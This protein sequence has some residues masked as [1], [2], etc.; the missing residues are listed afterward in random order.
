MFT[1]FGY[2]N[3]MDKGEL[4]DYFERNYLN[5]QLAHG[6]LSI[7]KL[8]EKLHLSKGY[9][10]QLM[11]G[12][13]TSVTY[14][15]ALFVAIIFN[16]FSI[17]EIL[18]YE[19]PDPGTI[20]ALALASAGIRSALGSSLSQIVESGKPFNSPESVELIVSRLKES[21]ATVSSIE[22]EPSEK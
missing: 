12:K 6:R 19:M 17:M 7:T 14:H 1:K 22:T 4:A 18:H 9:L 5:Y 10:S 8:A 2:I 11:E 21:G 20:R 16:D 13:R 15:T 3:F